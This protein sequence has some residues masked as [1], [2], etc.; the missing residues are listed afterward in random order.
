MADRPDFD[1]LAAEFLRKE[2]ASGC[3]SPD[4]HAHRS[5]QFLTDCHKFLISPTWAERAVA[6]GWD[7]VALFG[8]CR[9]R[10]LDR[11]GGAGLLWAVNGGRL[12]ELR[13]DWAIIELAGVA[14]HCRPPAS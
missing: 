8:C 13:R 5:L 10:P 7:A 1:R 6:S 2:L 12:V 11:P 9:H 14:A 4:I 3:P